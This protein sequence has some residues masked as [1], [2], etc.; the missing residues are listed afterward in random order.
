MNAR[1]DSSSKEEEEEMALNKGNKSLRELM[2]AW[3][4]VSTSKEATKSQVSPILPPPPSALPAD[5]GLKA[6][7][8]LKKERLVLELEE[9]E[10][11]PQKGAKQQKVAKD[12][13]DK[14]SS[15]V[16]SQEGQNRADVCFPQRTWS[17]WLKV[18]G[19]AIPWNASVRD[20]QRGCAGYLTEAL[21]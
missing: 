4:K 2:V 13:W 1:P 15:F 5:L 17:P 16:N 6:I 11:G 10:V 3:N 19:V 9:G 18:D 8:D 12:P 14:R 21:E 20:F 7:P